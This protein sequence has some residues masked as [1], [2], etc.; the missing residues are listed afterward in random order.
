MA[1][2]DITS[3]I[4]AFTLVRGGETRAN[5]AMYAA[6]RACLHEAMPP[7]KRF[8]HVIFFDGLDGRVPSAIREWLPEHIGRGVRFVDVRSYGGFMP[9][10]A[11]AAPPDL[12]RGALGYRQMCD[13]MTSR[14]PLSTV[15]PACAMRMAP[16]R[17]LCPL[18]QCRN[19]S[20]R[21]NDRAR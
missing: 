4:A 11:A 1:G 13:F 20:R 14:Q 5:F 7:D 9:A 15:P 3:R 8:D 19:D 2:F 6:T 18:S 12:S 21:P 16:S 17:R 10:R